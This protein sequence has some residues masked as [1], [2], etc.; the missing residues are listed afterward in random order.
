ME[1][2]NFIDEE[3]KRIV[4]YKW[5]SDDN[6]VK[7][8]VQIAH[9]MEER[10]GRYDYFAKKL[11]KAGYVVYA[12]DHRGHGAT[13]KNKEDLG[14]IADND[15]FNLMVKDMHQ[16]TDIIK[17][18]N[19]NIPVILFGHSM[20]SFLSLRYVEL[21]GENIDSLILSG[22]N[23]KP[24][25]ITKLGILISKHEI[26]KHGRKHLSN[27]MERLAIGG[28]NKNFM[29]YRTSSD[30]LSS[31]KEE[32]DKFVADEYCGFICT[33]SFYFD[34]LRGLWEMHETNNL[35]RIPK[36]LPIH[37]VSGEMDPVGNQGKGVISL[38]E[39][40]K[41]IGLENVNYKLYKD[42]RHEMLHEINKDEVIHNIIEWIKKDI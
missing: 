8:I 42:G 15:G 25:S 28:Y 37:M 4:Y 6:N 26:K 2:F 41:K 34:L 13:A 3:K 29:P 33:S 5:K 18:E 16:L 14:Y 10:A 35:G 22:T 38:Y 36:R 9:G 19:P 39:T 12:N 20:G 17:D 23:G 24:K 11:N 7:G 31:D 32:V 21:Y 30:W 27:V 1:Q 40:L